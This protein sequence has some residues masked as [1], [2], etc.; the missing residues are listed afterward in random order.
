MADS[1]GKYSIPSRP[2]HSFHLIVQFIA[3]CHLTSW[4]S[5]KGFGGENGAFWRTRTIFLA[6]MTWSKWPPPIRGEGLRSS[7]T[8]VQEYYE[9]SE[10]QKVAIV[11][12]CMDN[13]A[14]YYDGNKS[15]YWENCADIIEE[16]LSNC[17]VP[18]FTIIIANH[19]VSS[20]ENQR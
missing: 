9:L 15:R 12:I 8:L 1:N 7:T 14:G 3:A 5:E 4:S 17:S 16:T 10:E 11:Q 20:R 13:I 19:L 6:S 2:I 18:F